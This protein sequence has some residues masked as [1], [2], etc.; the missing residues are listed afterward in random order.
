MGIPLEENPV[1][2]TIVEK[3]PNGDNRHVD[4]V[5]KARWV[6][7]HTILAVEIAFTNILLVAILFVLAVK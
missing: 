4:E 6:W 3:L 7:Y 1:D 5:Y 2:K